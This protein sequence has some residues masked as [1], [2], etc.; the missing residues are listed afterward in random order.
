M[1]DNNSK[2]YN[3]TWFMWVS[4]I[5]FEPLGIFLMYKNKKYDLPVRIVFTIVFIGFFMAF[6]AP[7]KETKPANNVAKVETVDIKTESKKPKEEVKKQEPVNKKEEPVFDFSKAELTKE[8][9][10]KALESIINE[11][12]LKDITIS[13]EKGRNIIDVT[14]K[15]ETSFSETTLVKGFANTSVK[16]MEVLFKNPKIDNI[17]IWC[18]T[19]M[20]DEKGNDSLE[21]VVNV[22]LTKENA[23]DINWSKFKDMVLVDYNKL[24]NVAD[25]YFIYPGIANKLK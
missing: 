21:S 22:C 10:Q 9:I 23:K 11:D 2:F 15:V 4:L 18:K 7:R 13:N 5:L 8:N 3:K 1:K 16:A 25:K 24:F 19:N 20:M 14:Y 12:A 6:F 17:W